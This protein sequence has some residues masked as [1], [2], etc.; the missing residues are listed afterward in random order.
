MSLVAQ[1]PAARE[2]EISKSMMGDVT[3]KDGV[4]ISFER[5]GTG[6]ALILV[7]GALSDRKGG[8]LLAGRLSRQFTVYAFDRRGRGQSTNGKIYAV[9]H[10]IEDIEALIEHAGGSAYV[11]GVSSGA[12]L[13]LQTAAKLG[14]TKVTK[15][16][17]YEPPYTV[18]NEKQ[19]QDF[20]EQKRRVGEL[21]KTGRPGD[22][23]AYFMAAIGTPP[24]ALE[25]LKAS[26]A[27]PGM[28][29]IDFTLAY[30][31]A[32]LGDGSVPPAVAKAI[33]MPTLLLDG[34]KTMESLHAAADR[35]AALIPGAERKTLPG[36]THQAAPE[37]A[38]PV[39]IEF[40]QGK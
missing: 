6:P 17:L 2:S 16:A 38:A 40:F 9:E 25:K 28:A 37:V 23:A 34:E 7:G 32:V 1:Q 24:E 10:E 29:K 36:Q 5:S 30:D 31:Y 4:K 8:L 27:W 33:G 39:L 13:A 14:P 3:S 20:A 21:I 15:L 26:P 35:V 11:Y 18:G 22:A 12:A 19:R